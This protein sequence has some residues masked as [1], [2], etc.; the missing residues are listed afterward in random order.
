MGNVLDNEAIC[1]TRLT[2]DS[3]VRFARFVFLFHISLCLLSQRC[4]EPVYARV[5]LFNLSFAKQLPPLT[6]CAHRWVSHVVC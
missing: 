1:I 4:N 3:Y 5:Y 6:F 2:F